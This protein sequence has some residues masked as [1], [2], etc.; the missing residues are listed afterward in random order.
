[1]IENREKSETIETTYSLVFYIPSD[2]LISLLVSG[3]ISREFREKLEESYG[4][5]S[6]FLIP[7]KGS[8]FLPDPAGFAK[9]RQIWLPALICFQSKWPFFS[10]ALLNILRESMGEELVNL[11]SSNHKNSMVEKKQIHVLEK[12]SNRR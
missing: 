9:L 12:R 10:N 11:M 6:G 4:N 8:E 1:M 3:S 7:K 5:R 2:V